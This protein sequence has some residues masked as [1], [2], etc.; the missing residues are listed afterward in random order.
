MLVLVPEGGEF[1]AVITVDASIEQLER[2][3]GTP[4]YSPPGLR[5]TV[6]DQ[7]SRVRNKDLRPSGRT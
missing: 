3:A 4:P 6:L 7:A 1:P 5:V 2:P